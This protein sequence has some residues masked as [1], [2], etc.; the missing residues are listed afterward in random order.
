MMFFAGLFLMKGEGMAD[1]SCAKVVGRTDTSIFTDKAAEERCTSDRV[2]RPRLGRF[3]GYGDK[4][5]SGCN[6]RER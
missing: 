4:G 5:A 6:S 3:Q 1:Q 2:D